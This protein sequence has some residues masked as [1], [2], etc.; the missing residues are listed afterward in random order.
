SDVA[1]TDDAGGQAAP[2]RGGLDRGDPV[3]VDLRVRAEE[4]ANAIMAVR[5]LDLVVADDDRGPRA[6]AGRASGLAGG[7]RI[8]GTVAAPSARALR[9]AITGLAEVLRRG[10]AGA[11]VRAPGNDPVV[12]DQ[13]RHRRI[14]RQVRIGPHLD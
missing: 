10:A 11:E 5:Q 3:T 8:D 13:D 14:G 9:V 6:R 1:G 4:R 12:A 7:D 2:C